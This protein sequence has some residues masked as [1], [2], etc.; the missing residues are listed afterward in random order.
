MA[1]SWKFS[2]IGLV[3][4]TFVSCSNDIYPD[5]SV[6]IEC[7]DDEAPTAASSSKP[8]SEGT[9]EAPSLAYPEYEDKECEEENTASQT[10][11]EPPPESDKDGKRD[12]VDTTD[13]DSESSPT[14]EYED[15]DSYTEGSSESP[16]DYGNL[17][18]E[19]NQDKNVTASEL[20]AEDTAGNRTDSDSGEDTDDS[21]ITDDIDEA[22]A[23]VNGTATGGG[24][25]WDLQNTYY[26]VDEIINKAGA[27]DFLKSE[28]LQTF[29]RNDIQNH[30]INPVIRG[31]LYAPYFSKIEKCFDT[32]HEDAKAVTLASEKTFATCREDYDKNYCASR[33]SEE[34][35]VK[36]KEISDKIVQC[37]KDTG[38]LWTPS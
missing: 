38:T 19:I 7:P 4:V 31:I 6:E 27:Y 33:S 18:D 1:R 2:I 15:S 21:Q 29:I 11:T 8:S 16:D 24:E 35:G 9:S 32:V 3:Y 17:T 36:Y 12:N 30:L 20:T 13:E 37:V 26:K 25:E 28:I 10:T 5:N 14:K 34:A 23:E 22:D